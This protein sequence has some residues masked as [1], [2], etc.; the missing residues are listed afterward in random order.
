M[1][2]FSM[3]AVLLF[4]GTA[5]LFA[6]G[7]QSGRSA[8][9]AA[10]AAT[11]VVGNTLK[12]DLAAPVNGGRN[13]TIE[14][15]VN[16]GLLPVWQQL[17]DDYMKVHPNVRINVTPFGNDLLEK[18]APALQTGTGPD[19]TFYHNEWDG[20]VLPFAS[21][22]P[23][24]VLPLSAIKADF[25][26][27]DAHI[28]ADG[29]LYYFDM[30]IMTSGIFY[31]KKMWREAGLTEADIP[32]SWEQLIQVAKKLTK[33]DNAGNITREGLSINAMQE[34]I[35]QALS[36]Q[37]G[38]FL[39][40]AGNKPVVDSPVWRANLKFIQDLYNVHKVSST[41][42]PDGNEAFVNEQGAMSYIWGWAGT[43]LSN[44]PNM[45]WGFFNLPTKTGRTPPAYDRNN[46]ESTPAVTA[47]RVD[48]KAVG[49]DI[50]KF[51]LA[52]D[53]YLT[54]MAVLDGI[55]PVKKNLLSDPAIRNDVVLSTQTKMSDRTIWPGPLPSEYHTN[56]KTFA[57]QE[58]LLN[59]GSIDAA[60]TNTQRVMDRDFGQAFRNLSFQ[61]RFY[62]YSGELK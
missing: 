44:Y 54:G 40:T 15:W 37:D 24:D 59:G 9:P 42:F 11:G 48:A 33:Y 3:L 17:A 5:A 28:Q 31:N 1:K 2:R 8:A 7:G 10:P 55:V 26:M 20:T 12:Y 35:L 52:H 47:T 56:I 39:F 4:C 50:L 16:N 13:I 38:Q 58:V 43:W 22:Y 41:R 23:E 14:F 36:Y 18:I 21:P 49:F 51:F 45:E 19:I 62:G 30:G 60:L 57:I 29:K 53:K 6:G 27:I 46:G 25:N 32:A 61:E 34:F